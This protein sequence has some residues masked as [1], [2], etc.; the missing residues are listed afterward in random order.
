MM[1]RTAAIGVTL[2]TAA[3]ANKDAVGKEAKHKAPQRRPIFKSLKF[4]MIQE[5][6]SILD[7]F[8]LVQDLGY[9]GVELSSPGG[10]DKKQCL[11]AS[12]KTGLPIHGVVDSRH[13][14]VRATDP[15]AKHRKQC[16]DDLLIAIKESHYCG[17][18][19]VLF[20]TGH[21]NDGPEDEIIPRAI[22]VIHQALPLAAKLGVMIL[23]ENVWNRMFYD[24]DRKPEQTAQR[25]AAFIDACNSPWVGAYFDIGNHHKYGQPQAWIRTLG[26]RVVKLDVK[27]FSRDTNNWSAIGDGTINW[28]A[29]RT[30]L[31]EI[32]FTGW[33]TAEVG[34][35]DR[36]RLADILAR[37]NRVLPA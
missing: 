4:G 10:Q 19:S 3:L 29:V 25:Y 22:D 12:R 31:D 6:L 20:V 2:G 34:G 8:K 26:Q 14:R 18:S 36:K 17:G 16:L 9:D 23:I 21:G 32:G 7:K 15:D 11:E 27:G 5:S 13:W 28:P 1:R 33:C 35:G 37:L 24:H 30:A